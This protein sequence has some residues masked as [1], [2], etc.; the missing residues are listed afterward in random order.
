MAIYDGMAVQPGNVRYGNIALAIAGQLV[1]MYFNEV[2]S[3]NVKT[4]AIEFGSPVNFETDGT[5]T[6]LTDGTAV[7]AFKGIA[8]RELAREMDVRGVLAKTN[9]AVGA[10][11]GIIRKGH[12]YVQLAADAL[13]GATVGGAVYTKGGLFYGSA[14][15]AATDGLVALTGVTFEAVATAGKVVEIRLA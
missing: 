14:N 2:V 9:Y 5:V 11:A 13:V 12:V 4:A 10:T 6:T 1:D 3:A 15:G 7:T 8:V